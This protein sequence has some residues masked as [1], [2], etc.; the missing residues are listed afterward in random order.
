M[1]NSTSRHNVKVY[2]LKFKPSEKL[3][4]KIERIND[5]LDVQ[6]RVSD[7]ECQIP[8]IPIAAYLNFRLIPTNGFPLL[9]KLS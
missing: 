7:P 1:I 3:P 5:G 9:N 2:D 8:S 4:V 6:L